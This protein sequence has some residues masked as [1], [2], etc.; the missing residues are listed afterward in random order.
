MFKA[1]NADLVNYIKDELLKAELNTPAGIYKLFVLSFAPSKDAAKA[2]CD[3]L[4]DP[5]FKRVADS[6]DGISSQ[7]LG[8]AAGNVQPNRDA[9]WMRKAAEG[10]LCTFDIASEFGGDRL[11]NS[12]DAL[13]APGL[14]KVAVPGQLFGQV[15]PRL[16]KEFLSAVPLMYGFTN[17]SLPGYREMPAVER[18]SSEIASAAGREPDEYAARILQCAYLSGGTVVPPAIDQDGLKDLCGRISACQGKDAV[19]A[20]LIGDCGPWES[21]GSLS[22]CPPWKSLVNTV[23][24]LENALNSAGPVQVQPQTTEPSSE[25][26]ESLLPLDDNDENAQEQEQAVQPSANE[27]PAAVQGRTPSSSTIDPSTIGTLDYRTAELLEHMSYDEDQLKEALDSIEYLD[28]STFPFLPY[29]TSYHPGTTETAVAKL[30]DGF[31]ARASHRNYKLSRGESGDRK[32]VMIPPAFKVDAAPAIWTRA[33]ISGMGFP[34]INFTCP[35]V[36]ELLRG[37]DPAKVRRA[38][39]NVKAMFKQCGL[40]K[41]ID[42]LKEF[43]RANYRNCALNALTVEANE[44]YAADPGTTVTASVVDPYSKV[45]RTKGSI[46]VSMDFLTMFY[47]V[48]SPVTAI[49]QY[50]EVCGL[51]PKDYMAYLSHYGKPPVYILNP[52]RVQFRRGPRGG[53]FHRLFSSKT[54]PVLVRA[55]VNG[56]D[57]GLLVP[58]KVADLIFCE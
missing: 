2:A 42:T 40:K 1:A 52:K 13:T 19:G 14:A 37:T 12:F 20:A 49:R 9:D 24:A 11:K 31:T 35:S 18:V 7:A 30:L 17:A 25:S 43:A 28:G 21:A 53:L 38:Y 48:L 4:A 10:V 32:T 39:R 44:L 22:N 41:P 23:P 27:Q 6:L 26:G 45:S 33:V 16:F 15:G 46:P 56:H 57:G 54:A 29:L 51:E 36:A 58:E 47:T 5:R 8:D 55:R 34:F 3:M 50:S